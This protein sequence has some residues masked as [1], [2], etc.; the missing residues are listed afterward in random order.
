MNRK[1]NLPIFQGKGVSIL[2]LYLRVMSFR[3]F[4]SV[5]L[6]TV[7]T[8]VL[9]HNFIPHHHHTEITAYTGYCEYTHEHADGH[10]H[11]HPEH[12]QHKNEAVEFK[13]VEHNQENETHI[14][15]SFEDALVLNKRL[16]LSDIYVLFVSFAFVN[17]EEENKQLTDTYTAQKIAKPHC[18]DVQLR[19]PPQFS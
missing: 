3:N 5:F 18:R 6:L 11:I 10:K 2:F 9:A 16:N 7:Y 15:C 1:C 8:V 19:G 14:H 13:K 12:H 17:A 4:I